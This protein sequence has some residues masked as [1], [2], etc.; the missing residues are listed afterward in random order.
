MVQINAIMIMIV[1]CFVSSV[2]VRV[3]E[4]NGHFLV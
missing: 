2:C 3:Y 4:V 1:I